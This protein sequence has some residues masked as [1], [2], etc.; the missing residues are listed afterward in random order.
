MTDVLLDLS[1]RPFI[2]FSVAYSYTVG[3]FFDFD[4]KGPVTWEFVI[5]IGC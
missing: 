3:I 2:E 1:L 4:H 5:A